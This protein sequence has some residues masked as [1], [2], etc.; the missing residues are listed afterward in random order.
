MLARRGGRAR[1]NSVKPAENETS[2]R[3]RAA[4]ASRRA[5]ASAV[6][7]MHDAAETPKR[8]RAHIGQQGA[9]K[10]KLCAYNKHWRDSTLR[11]CT[12]SGD[13]GSQQ[14]KML[15]QAEA[16]LRAARAEVRRE[17]RA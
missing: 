16:N 9:R 17:L 13:L 15:Q 12:A 6:S 7:P 4:C 10:L 3:L 1:R 14:L 2:S 8:A 5:E 11:C